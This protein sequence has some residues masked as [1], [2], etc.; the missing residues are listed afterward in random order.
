MGSCPSVGNH[1]AC[2]SPLIP[3]GQNDW[4]THCSPEL[5]TLVTAL[6]FPAVFLANMTCG[7]LRNFGHAINSESQL[8]VIRQHAN[9]HDV[10]LRELCTGWAATADGQKG[11]IRWRTTDSIQRWRRFNTMQPD[12]LCVTVVT[13]VTDIDH[14]GVLNV[15]SI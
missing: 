7:L 2:L 3:S 4:I 15:L 10:R 11:K 8:A 6:P 13:P 5:A 12:L 14:W 9:H 1:A